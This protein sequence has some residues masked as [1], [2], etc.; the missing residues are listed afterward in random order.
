MILWDAEKVAAGLAANYDGAPPVNLSLLP[1]PKRG[2]ATGPEA[3]KEAL[4]GDRNDTLNRE[5]FKDASRGT[6]DEPAY[7]EVALRIGLDPAEIDATLASARAGGTITPAFPRRDKQALVE[8]LERMG[9][10]LRYNVRYQRTEI[11]N[12]TESWCEHRRIDQPAICVRSW[13]GSS[14]TRLREIPRR[15]TSATT[16]GLCVSKIDIA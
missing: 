14:D 6:L 3:V 4:P 10:A 5:A 12:G 15:L 16:H 7:R 9:V 2:G 8:G 13:R 1:K 11:K